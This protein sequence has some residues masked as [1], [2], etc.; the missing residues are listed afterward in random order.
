MKMGLRLFVQDGRS[1]SSNWKAAIYLRVCYAL[2]KP[3]IAE[4]FEK[5]GC[6]DVSDLKNFP[7]GKIMKLAI[8]TYP[9]SSTQ[10]RETRASG[11]AI[12]ELV[13]PYLGGDEYGL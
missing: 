8:K 5:Y 6:D 7:A 1:S 9:I 12:D 10:I 3:V 13:K 4:L 11:K 2:S